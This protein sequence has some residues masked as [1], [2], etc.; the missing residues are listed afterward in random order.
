M[1]RTWLRIGLVGAV[2][3]GLALAC[4]GII[5]ELVLEPLGRT[6]WRASLFL[7]S[8]HQLIYWIL[9]IAAVAMIGLVGWISRWRITGAPAAA[10]PAQNGPVEALAGQIRQAR[11]GAYFQWL[12]ANRLGGLARQ[13]RPQDFPETTGAR[14][15]D[16]GL[17]LSQKTRR[18]LEAGL[19]YSYSQPNSQPSRLRQPQPPFDVDLSQVITDLENHLEM[20]SHES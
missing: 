11:R 10:A 19:D 6:A 2:L 4:Q 1:K 8:Q 13:A 7:R 16:N 5:L 17:S 14:R 18:Y 12:V 3:V 15:P 20:K 9:L